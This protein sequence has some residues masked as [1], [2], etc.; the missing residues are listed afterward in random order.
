[1]VNNVDGTKNRQGKIKYYCWL[2][3]L[4]QKKIMWMKFY[5]TNLGKDWF[6]LGYPFLFA[7]NPDVDWRRVILKGGEVGLEAIGF[8]QAQRRVD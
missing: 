1:M 7:F 2:K 6:I 8:Q 4:Y 3:V 5:L